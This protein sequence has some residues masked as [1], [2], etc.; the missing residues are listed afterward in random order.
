MFHS[1]CPEQGEGRKRGDAE[2]NERGERE[3]DGEEQEGDGRRIN[4]RKADGLK[5]YDR[6]K[7]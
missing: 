6:K 7:A 1:Q 3:K 5:E 2:R 4:D